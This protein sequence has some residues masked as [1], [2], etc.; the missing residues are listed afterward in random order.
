MTKRSTPNGPA[1]AIVEVPLADPEPD[2]Y[3]SRHVQV[4]LDAEQRV[5]MRRLLN[6][7]RQ[8]NEHL[9]SGRAVQS[10]AN[11][12]EWVLEQIAKQ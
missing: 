10:N 7:L 11:A 4:Q 12:I 1:S 9:A 8:A 3:L 5:A 2:S 6:G